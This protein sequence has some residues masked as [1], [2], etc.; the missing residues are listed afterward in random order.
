MITTV[1]YFLLRSQVLGDELSGTVMQD[2]MNNPFLQWDGGS[3]VVSTAEVRIATMFFVFAKYVGLMVFPF[4]LVHDYY[5]FQIPLQTFSSGGVW[6]GLLLFAGM[7]GYGF[8][9]L[10]K[11]R[12]EGFGLL[13]FL[14]GLLPVSNLLFPVGVF[15][16]ERFLYL[17]SLGFLLAIIIM[18]SRLIAVDRHRWIVL[19]AL[20]LTGLF[21]ILTVKRN[22]AWKSNET[23]VLTD[24]RYAPKSAKLQNG[25]GTV[26]LNKALQE[27][28]ADRQKRLLEEA[29]VYLQNSNTLHP[30]YYDAGL[31]LGACAYYL[32]KFDESANAYRKIAERH[33]GDQ[34]AKTGLRYALEAYGRDKL[35]KGDTLSAIPVLK[36]AWTIYPDTTIARLLADFYRIKQFP[37]SSA[38]WQSRVR[39]PLK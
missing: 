31:A 25:A 14:I 39:G 7:V 28:D 34:N 3:W 20:A 11:R 10:Y 12:Q 15:M 19:S 1:I 4:A 8:Y 18:L 26:L 22:Q 36:Q 17:P 23:L 2:P 38:L 6:I 29:Y 13:L 35:M 37:D 30:T 32:E 24:V 5:P 27:K 33:P 9:A 16:A 21:S